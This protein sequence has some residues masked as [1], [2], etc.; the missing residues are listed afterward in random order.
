MTEVAA[1]AA[2]AVYVGSVQSLRRMSSAP[3]SMRERSGGI[4]CVLS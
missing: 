3:F 2:T 4:G 1:T